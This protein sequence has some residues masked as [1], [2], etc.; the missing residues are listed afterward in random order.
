MYNLEWLWKLKVPTP[1]IYF[2]CLVRRDRLLTNSLRARCHGE[3]AVIWRAFIPFDK[4]AD[5]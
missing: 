5:F 4:W 2:L 3:S 1:W